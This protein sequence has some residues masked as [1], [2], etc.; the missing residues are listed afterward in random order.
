M[1]GTNLD[2]GEGALKHFQTVL[3]QRLIGPFRYN[4][5]GPQKDAQGKIASYMAEGRRTGTCYRGNVILSLTNTSYTPNLKDSVEEYEIK[6]PIPMNIP[7]K[8]K[9]DTDQKGE[10]GPAQL[11]QENSNFV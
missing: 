1:E 9:N 4:M 7:S 3:L 2:E 10:M 6:S 11:R 8:K 5:Y